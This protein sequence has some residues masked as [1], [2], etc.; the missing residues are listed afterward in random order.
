MPYL[1]GMHRYIPGS[2]Y[3][4]KR[5]FPQRHRHCGVQLEV[6]ASHLGFGGSSCLEPERHPPPPRAGTVDRHS[7]RQVIIEHTNKR[8]A[9][10]SKRS[11][12]PSNLLGPPPR[13]LIFSVRDMTKLQIG[14]PVASG[15]CPRTVTAIRGQGQYTE[16]HALAIVTG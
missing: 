6:E 14:A 7:T 5:F 11:T 3:I 9:T 1:C 2:I 12:G 4:P 15:V 8:G 13:Y 10:N 16:S